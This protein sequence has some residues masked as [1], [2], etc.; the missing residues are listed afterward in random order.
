MENKIRKAILCFNLTTTRNE[1]INHI[2]SGGPWDEDFDGPQ[3]FGI[4]DF[5]NDNIHPIM[6]SIYAELFH[7]LT[8]IYFIVESVEDA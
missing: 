8:C 2:H 5:I 4:N 6:Q 3:K 7:R 1:H